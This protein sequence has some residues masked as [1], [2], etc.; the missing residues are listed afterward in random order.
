[1]TGAEKPSLAI[2]ISGRGSNMQAFI[3]AC[4]SG[5]LDATIGLIISNN[6]DAAGLERAKL[7][8]VTT[9]V[10]VPVT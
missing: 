9:P 1:M 2:L 7:L 6:P 3:D 5:E 4:A 8:L 10:R